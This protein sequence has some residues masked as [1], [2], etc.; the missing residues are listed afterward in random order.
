MATKTLAL[1]LLLAGAI[2]PL[3]CCQHWSYGLNPGGKRDLDGVSDTLGNLIDVFPHVDS[4]C[5]VLGC[6]EESPL[7]RFYRSKGFVG[8]VTE[9][10]NGHIAY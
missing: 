2:L 1:C 7:A 9:R 4:P 10:E 6:G 5:T 3:G 8:S